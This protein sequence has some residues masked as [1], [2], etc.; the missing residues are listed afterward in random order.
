MRAAIYVRVSTDEQAREGF[1]ISAQRENLLKY[2]E[3]E[4]WEVYDTYI[5]DGYSAKDMNRPEL[6]RLLKDIHARNVDIVLVMKLDR[7]TRS[8]R[9]L[10]E[11][12]DEFEKHHCSFYSRQERFDISSSMGRAMLGM[13]G[14]FAQWERETIAE[15]VRFGMEQMV[16]EGK[17]PGAPKPFGYDK[18]GNQIPEEVAILHEMRRLYMKGNGFYTVAQTLNRR[19]LLHRGAIW[20]QQYVKYCLEN[21]YYAGYL[22]WGKDSKHE[23]IIVKGNHQPVWTDEEYEAHLR[24]MRI[25]SGKNFTR[26]Y[27]FWFTG[28]LRCGRCGESLV[29]RV[30]KAKRVRKEEYFASFYRC[31][32]RSNGT[33]CKLPSLRQELI[34]HLIFDYISQYKLDMESAE[35]EAKGLNQEH[36]NIRNK[37]EM[38][39][40]ELGKI[41]ERKKKWQRMCANELIT[42][43]EL[44][45]YLIEEREQEEEILSQLEDL[46]DTPQETPDEILTLPEI[47]P[48]LD[49]QQKH[50]VVLSIFKRIVVNAPEE[51]QPPAGKFR[52]AYIVSIEYN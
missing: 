17:R 37:R 6:K 35:K 42:E 15:R 38:L 1:S 4:G 40:K 31:S 29:G 12:L 51:R 50:E 33:G 16:K 34:E 13:L 43:S 10:Y 25:R 44:R 30:V 18:N 8:V 45:E 20:T 46:P 7:L 49:D 32:G 27:R 5:D 19:N 21:P 14:I 41:R 52:N 24:R 48:D 9:D 39:E 28:V 36:M 47:W 11:L 2:A 22:R 23:E 3:A 26:T